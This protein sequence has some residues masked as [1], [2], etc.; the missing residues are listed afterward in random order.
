MV[1]LLTKVCAHPQT[2]ADF[3]DLGTGTGVHAPVTYYRCCE[4]LLA[5]YIQAAALKV[6]HQ[7]QGL[8]RLGSLR[9]GGKSS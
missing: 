2:G 7:N 4:G 1:R 9:L 6:A 3:L 5:G 8:S